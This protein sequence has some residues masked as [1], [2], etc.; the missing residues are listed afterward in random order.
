MPQTIFDVVTKDPEIK[1]VAEDVRQPAVHE[2]RCDQRQPDWYQS[3]L[4]SGQ[5]HAL[6]G[7]WLDHHPIGRDYIAPADN[8]G[9]HRRISIGELVIRSQTL[10]EHKHK[11]VD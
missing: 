4:Q 2:H 11:Q 5:G 1:H 6:A 8:F 3:A 9:R 7:D 10:Q